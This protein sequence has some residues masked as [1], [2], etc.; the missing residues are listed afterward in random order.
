MS[1]YAIE[2]LHTYH[3]V[4]FSLSLSCY[5]P[6]FRLILFSPHRLQVCVMEALSLFFWLRQ[7]K[8]R[9]RDNVVNMPTIHS[10]ILPSHTGSPQPLQ[11]FSEVRNGTPYKLCHLLWLNQRLTPKCWVYPATQ[12]VPE[13]C[14]DVFPLVSFLVFSSSFATLQAVNNP[15][16]D[17]TGMAAPSPTSIA[18]TDC[19]F[20]WSGFKA[21]S[22]LSACLYPLPLKPWAL[23]W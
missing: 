9:T 16:S 7:V 22:F 18:G 4:E 17:L 5:L 14:V 3:R 8:S 2:H 19:F 1:Q 10:M 6:A 11:I 13:S 12:I 21:T 20:D 15:V 23:C